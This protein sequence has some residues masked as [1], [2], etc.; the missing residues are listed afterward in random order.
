VDVRILG[1]AAG[2][3][4]PQWNC[5][6]RVC[7]AA[8]NGNGRAK[9]R[10]QSSIAVRAENGPWFL[11]NASPDLRQ[12]IAALPDDR[13]DDLRIMPFAGIVLTD[14]EIDH[15]A[16]LLLMRESHVPLEIYSSE[17][18]RQALTDYYPVLT[19]LDRYCGIRWNQLD[20]GGSV[21]LGGSLEV[22]AFPTGGDPPLYMG[23][24]DNGITS[25]GLTIK[26]RESG[27]TFTYAP[28]LE[29]LDDV[30]EERFRG[31]DYVCVD[32]TFWTNDE[33]VSLGLA[34]RDA[35]A[36]GHTP[37][38]GPNGSLA[39]LESLPARTILVHINN[40]NP[41]LLEDSAELATVQASGIDVARDGM[42]ISL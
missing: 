30:I 31:S 40:T 34:K 5:N 16:G 23:D 21:V 20:P 35:W 15:T 19:M 27:G 10:T 7:T 13:T 9:P 33:L 42:E 25:M 2:G 14:A 28:A 39:V 26:D 22:E 8:R 36:M 3:G 6:C 37:L 17:A 4:Y 38:T 32:G 24:N 12:Q 11:I 29:A 18:V 41:I 1:S